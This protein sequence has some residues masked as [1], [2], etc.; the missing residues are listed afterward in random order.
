M[1]R[2]VL[3]L[4]LLGWSTVVR[5]A[6]RQVL[7]YEASYLGIPLLDMTLTTTVTDTSVKISYDN[8]LKPLIA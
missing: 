3:L 8:R 2:T 5:P 4:L 6:G 1:M 7:Q